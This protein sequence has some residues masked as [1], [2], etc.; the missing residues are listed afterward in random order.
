MKCTYSIED[1]AG[2]M[3]GLMCDRDKEKLHE[4]LEICEDCRNHLG[5]LKL[6]ES[7]I[8]SEVKN[9]GST[10]SRVM[11]SIDKNRYKGK[12]SRYRLGAV[13]FKLK[14]YLMPLAAA[15]LI[16]ILAA[17]ALN[18][19]QHISNVLSSLED[20]VSRHKVTD[21]DKNKKEEKANSFF[22]AEPVTELTKGTP[23]KGWVF[24][25]DRVLKGVVD[26]GE[27]TIKLYVK[28][29]SNPLSS[30]TTGEVMAYVED[31]GDMYEIG[32]VS[33]Y[34]TINMEFKAQDLNNDGINEISIKGQM[35]ASSV[36]FKV[37]GCKQGKWLK[38]LDTDYTEVID[39]DSDGDVELVCTSVGSVPPYVWIYRWN[40]GHFEKLDVALAT[41]NEYAN[42]LNR[43]T[44]N[45]ILEC[46]S[47]NGRHY[48]VYKDGG[49]IEENTKINIVSKD[50]V[51]NQYFNTIVT[52][53]VWGKKGPGESYE[54]IIKI[55][56]GRVIKI[57]GMCTRDGG[58][59]GWYVA[60][61]EPELK[62]DRS[63]I[64][65]PENQTEFCVRL[66]DLDLGIQNKVNFDECAIGDAM[67]FESVITGGNREDGNVLLK[68][69]PDEKSPA[70]SIA[71][72]GNI[73]SV[74]RKD[75]EWSLVKIISGR[76][77]EDY[78]DIGWLKNE[79]YSEYKPGMKVNQGFIKRPF[80]IYEKPDVNSNYP[81]L[82]NVLKSIVPVT[83]VETDTKSGWS[84]VRGGFNGVGG[85]VK[86]EDIKFSFSSEEVDKLLNP[87]VDLKLLT[88]KIKEEIEGCNDLNL[89]ALDMDKK[90]ELS[91]SQ[92]KELSKKLTEVTGYELNDGGVS[93]HREAAYPFYVLNFPGDESTLYTDE[94]LNEPTIK[95]YFSKI[96][97]FSFV[98]AGDDRLLIK[99][100]YKKLGSYGLAR[101]G[102]SVRFLSVSKEFIDCIKAL[103]PASANTDRNSF[104]HLLSAK[105][106]EITGDFKEIGDRSQQVCKTARVLKAFAGDEFKP[107]KEPDEGTRITEFKFIFKDGS[108]EKI[109]L[110]NKYMKYKGRY[111]SL[112]GDP[113]SIEA[114]L[115][116]AY[117]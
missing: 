33:N 13:A 14:P 29:D 88:Q 24:S 75:Q 115:F 15:V 64:I 81:P 65:L 107:E 106:V 11:E 20:M 80:R 109:M 30:K 86:T 105:K 40:G 57:S 26:N 48:Y 6:T 56:N 72:L 23:S 67:M 59:S 4:H 69:L 116:A 102:A 76:A 90:V 103:I 111:Y 108:Y 92:R 8:K 104:N 54:D 83:I 53:E 31:G 21:E 45:V 60:T 61:M 46:G 73:I 71:D 34:G 17:V 32:M 41:G 95:H 22:K 63:K 68:Q 62:D 114:Q 84:R 93:P 52:K 5:I 37:I 43:G 77:M 96:D 66:D 2:Y 10:Y 117:F 79:Y 7:H 39:L 49:L 25:E 51:V 16:V 42:L 28:P 35:G 1:L 94:E 74:V 101:E 36:A 50:N 9:D 98:V 58:N 110:F 38:L 3:E 112:D 82:D 113:K 12:K 91:S 70:V 27:T 44:D 19:Q 18:N 47:Q 99:I 87:D 100:P 55:P 78:S 97:G 85:W 89:L